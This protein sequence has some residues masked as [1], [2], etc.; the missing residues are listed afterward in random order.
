MELLREP[1]QLHIR[2]DGRLIEGDAVEVEPGIFSVLIDGHAF[3]V[4]IE[5][6]ANG[7]RVYVSRSEYLLGVHD[8]RQW[9]RNRGAALEADGRQ[10]L[11][12]PMP[13]KVIRVLAK[14]GDAVEAGQGLLVVEAMKMQNEIRSPKTGVIERIVVSEGQTVN[15]GEVLGVIV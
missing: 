7:S 6:Q 12:A 15:A 10:Q 2:I 13:G 11:L 14:A 9:N 3:E 5:K 8:P 1:R 4:R